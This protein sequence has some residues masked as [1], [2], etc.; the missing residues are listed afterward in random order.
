MS[1]FVVFGSDIGKSNC[2]LSEFKG[3]DNTFPLTAGIPIKESLKSNLSFRMHE[4]WPNHT[5]MADSLTN[6]NMVVVAS[7]RLASFFF[8]QQVPNIEIIPITILDH[9]GAACSKSYKIIHPINALDA[10]DLNGVNVTHS[11]ILADEIES[12]DVI[13]LDNSK[14]PEQVQI[15]RC[16]NLANF[17]FVRKPFAR[18]ISEAGFSGIKWRELSEVSL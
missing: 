4:D 17:V 13:K 15:F 11:F 10:L 3:M 14:I 18:S 6:T 5:T 7:E 16:K 2:V 1:D 9:S 12:I 8:K